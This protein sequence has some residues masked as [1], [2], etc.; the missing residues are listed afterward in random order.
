MSSSPQDKPIFQ[1]D[2]EELAKRTAF[3]KGQR[4]K[5]LAM[6]VSQLV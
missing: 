1:V 2:P 4:D 5:L 6:K 3:L